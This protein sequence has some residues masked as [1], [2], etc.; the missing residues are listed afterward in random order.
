M[1]LEDLVGRLVD[2]LEYYVNE[3][4]EPKYKKLIDK[5]I[6]NGRGGRVWIDF[7]DLEEFDKDLVE[8]ASKEE[9][10]EIIGVYIQTRFALKNGLYPGAELKKETVFLHEDFIKSM[11][12]EPGEKLTPEEVAEMYE[13]Y[14]KNIN[15]EKVVVVRFWQFVMLMIIGY[16]ADSGK[17]DAPD[18]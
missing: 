7:G 9:F 1:E 6:E 2:F 14:V 12:E 11:L 10:A 5:K 4:G 15:G 16:L 3:N 18:D 8:E 13:G 17:L